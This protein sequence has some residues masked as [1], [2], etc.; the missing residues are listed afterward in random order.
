MAKKR[1]ERTRG[2]GTMT[3][4][5]F[6]QMIRSTLRRASRWWKP[7][8][9]CRNNARRK[10][11]GK[12]KRQKWEYQ[13]N[14]CKKWFPAKETNV[15]HITP[16]GQLNCAKDLPGF[17]ERLFCETDGLQLL[18]SNCHDIKTKKEKDGNKCNK[19]TSRRSNRKSE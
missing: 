19:T 15:D 3:E 5:Q 7:V 16:V 2:A 10:Y 14:N 13:C 9:V 12:N 17:V 4:A 11:E 1:K 18:C 8:S 6:W